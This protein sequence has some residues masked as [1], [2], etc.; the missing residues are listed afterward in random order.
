[1]RNEPGFNWDRQNERHLGNHGITRLYAE[2]VLLGNHILM[3]FQ[4][5]ESEE[6]WVAVGLTRSGRILNI[7][8]TLRGEAI[9]PITGWLAD[10]ETA[11]S[12]LEEWGLG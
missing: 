6:R 1:V 3:E 8:F 10:R 5:E 12:Y 2:D 11:A 7:V 9:R 4:A